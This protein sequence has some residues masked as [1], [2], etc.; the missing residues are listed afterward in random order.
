MSQPMSPDVLSGYN[1]DEVFGY[2][3]GRKGVPYLATGATQN[4]PQPTFGLADVESVFWKADGENDE[5][6]WVC[7]GKL[8]DGRFFMVAASCDYTGWG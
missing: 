2:A 3:D 6:E 1:W 8:K 5:S 7:A 4:E